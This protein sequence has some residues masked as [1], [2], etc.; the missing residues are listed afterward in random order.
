[1]STTSCRPVWWN[2]ITFIFYDSLATEICNGKRCAELSF[3]LKAK[4]G[5]EIISVH[6]I[7]VWTIVDNDY[8]TLQALITPMKLP[9]SY[10][11]MKF[12]KWLESLSKDVEFTFE[13][14]KGRCRILKTGIPLNEIEVC[15]ALSFAE[16]DGLDK[17]LEIMKNAIYPIILMGTRQHGI[18]H[19]AWDF[20]QDILSSDMRIKMKLIFIGMKVMRMYLMILLF[21]K[22]IKC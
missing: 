14:N 12:S 2:E 1:M 22:G 9:T 5:D 16:E 21:S 18:G 4:K 8:L 17:K 11:G 13:I 19:L 3:T 20:D 6:C 10:L 15:N 7:G